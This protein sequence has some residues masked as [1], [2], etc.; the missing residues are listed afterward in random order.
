MGN[1]CA[2]CGGAL[3]KGNIEV[4]RR[5]GKRTKRVHRH[6]PSSDQVA[7]SLAIKH[8]TT[9]PVGQAVLEERFTQ[10][11]AVKVDAEITGGPAAVKVTYESPPAYRFFITQS[12][13]EKIRAALD[14]PISSFGIRI[15]ILPVPEFQVE[16]NSESF[17]D[18]AEVTIDWKVK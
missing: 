6:C 14:R 17:D 11:H 1:N 13:A 12:T 10:G 16:A 5:P 7:T 2:K 9:K 4:I 18:L 8:M 15:D 3:Y